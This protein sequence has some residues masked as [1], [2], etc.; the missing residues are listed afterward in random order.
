MHDWVKKDELVAA[1]ISI[2]VN[3]KVLYN[4][5]HDHH[6]SY[7]LLSPVVFLNE[8]LYQFC[9]QQKRGCLYFTNRLDDTAVY[10]QRGGCCPVI[11]LNTV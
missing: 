8:G 2:R 1:N 7:N 6:Q 3:E 10:A 11:V 9:Q 4:F 5:Y